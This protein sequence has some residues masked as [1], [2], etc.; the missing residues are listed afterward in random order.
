MRQGESFKLNI[1][2]YVEASGD[3]VQGYWK[4]AA[5]D[6]SGQVTGRILAGGFEGELS[7]PCF[8]LQRFR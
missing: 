3:A 5:R 2:S 7:A 8:S 4:E 1:H 6:V